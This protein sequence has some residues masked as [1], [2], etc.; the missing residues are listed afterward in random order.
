MDKY[1]VLLSPVAYRDLESIYNYIANKLQAP[2]TAL[3]LVDSIQEAILSLDEKPKRGAVRKTGVYADR[4]YRQRFV[5]NYVIVYRVDDNSRTV[6]VHTI[7]YAP[8]NF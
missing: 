3:V 1:R 8:S 2:E 4:D 6:I 5:K 7:R